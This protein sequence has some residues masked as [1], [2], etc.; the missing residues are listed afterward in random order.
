MVRPPQARE[1][2]LDASQQASSRKTT[3]SNN[4]QLFASGS[5]QY[6]SSETFLGKEA[7]DAYHDEQDNSH[8]DV[9]LSLSLSPIHMVCCRKFALHPC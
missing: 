7:Q 3:D 2:K 8:E 4:H 1:R 6:E 9:R 5:G